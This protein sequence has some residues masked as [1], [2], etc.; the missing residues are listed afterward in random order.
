VL[1]R[2]TIIEVVV[3]IAGLTSML[4]WVT[5]DRTIWALVSGS[6]CSSMARA[7]LSH[8]LLPGNPNRWQWDFVALREIRNFG[9]WIFLSSIIGFFVLN[10]DRLM[11]GAFVNA[12]ELG[13]YVI[14]YLIF[15]AV[16]QVLSKIILDVAFPVLS[17]I[18]RDRPTQLKEGYY[19]FQ[20]VIA[21]FSFFCSG[22]LVV[23]A[24]ILITLLYDKRY[25]DAGWMLAILSIGLIAMPFRIATECFMALGMPQ[26]LSHVSSIRLVSLFL[27]TPIGFYFFD[28]PGALWAI[29]LSQLSWLPMQIAYK[30]KYG[31]FDLKKELLQLMALLVG[32]FAGAGFEFLVAVLRRS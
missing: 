23:T 16:E 14:A 3:Q 12:T 13:V 18:V 10:G 19:R 1:G 32:I 9:K 24:R 4:C 29:T 6:I 31:L 21:S 30:I 2:I 11:L 26:V 22:F 20:T 5:F 17:E 28:L 15:A 8:A 27:L 25:E 7:I